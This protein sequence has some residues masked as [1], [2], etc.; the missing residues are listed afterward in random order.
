MMEK[1]SGEMKVRIILLFSMLAFL[2][3]VVAWEQIFIDKTLSSLMNMTNELYASLEEEDLVVSKAQANQV[4]KFWKEKEGVFSLIEDFRDIEQVGKQTSYILSYL[5]D[6]DFELARS[7]CKQ[8]LHL[9]SNFS[10]MIKFDV[11]NIF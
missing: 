5:D 1:G 3:G 2:I 6:E 4:H 7:E 11:H 10:K 8:F 9:L